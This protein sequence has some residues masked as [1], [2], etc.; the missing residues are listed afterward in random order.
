MKALKTV[1][2]GKVV[3]LSLAFLLGNALTRNVWHF[4]GEDRHILGKNI[5]SQSDVYRLL[6]YWTGSKT[7]TAKNNNKT[8]HSEIV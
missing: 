6:I 1:V 7:S 8:Q 3:Q 5:S 2:N 4:A